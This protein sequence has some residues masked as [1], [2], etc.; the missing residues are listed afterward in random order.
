MFAASYHRY[1]VELL[2]I[3]ICIYGVSRTQSCSTPCKYILYYFQ[4]NSDMSS[5]ASMAA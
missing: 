2:D 3:C 4:L 5:R 1:P